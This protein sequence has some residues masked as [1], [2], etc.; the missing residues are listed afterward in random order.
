[1]SFQEM[2]IEGAWVHTPLR[3]KDSRGYFEE[4]FKLSSI[5]Q[6]LGIN[7]EVKQGNQSVSNAG[8]IRGVHWTDSPQGQ[9]KYVSCMRGSIWDVVVD[10]RKESPTYGK[11]DSVELNPQNGK[12][13]IL[14]EGLGHAFLALEAGTLVNYLCTAEYDSK[15]DRTINPLDPTLAIGFLQIA[16]S[17]GIQNLSMSE[18]DRAG[19]V[20]GDA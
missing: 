11:W 20:F 2:K 5:E 13:M 4:Q 7:F 9:A 17:F 8:V 6:E 16:N 15:A 12:S 14:S 19:E 3:Y 18:R 1:M 10:L